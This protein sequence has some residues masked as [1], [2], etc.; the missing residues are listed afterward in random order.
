[1]IAADTATADH[2]VPRTVRRG[3]SAG[4]AAGKAASAARAAEHPRVRPARAASVALVSVAGRDPW[5]VLVLSLRVLPW[6]E[7]AS[8][9]RV[10]QWARH[11]PAAG[12]RLAPHL[13][14]L[15]WARRLCRPLRQRA[16][17]R[18]PVRLRHLR[19]RR[20]VRWHSARV[21]QR[22]RPRPSRSR[23]RVRRLRHGACLQPRRQR[24]RPQHQHR[25]PQRRR[26]RQRQRVQ[27]LQRP[28]GPR[29]Q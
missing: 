8:A 2:P 23:R 12:H 7:P 22:R 26:H 11:S 20:R 27:L 3:S 5:A 16:A 28:V 18:L 24:R 10:L 4:T 13:R 29:L 15:P 1:M 19:H 14:V 6:V 9:H 17:P 25:H 21:A